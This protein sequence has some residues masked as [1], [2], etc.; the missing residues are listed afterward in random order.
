MRNVIAF[1]VALGLVAAIFWLTRSE[2]DVRRP[3]VATASGSA[4]RAEPTVAPTKIDAPSV[5]RLDKPAREALRAQIAAARA[6]SSGSSSAADPAR[7]P[8]D[9]MTLELSSP[10]QETL[11]PTIPIVAECYA[12]Q[13]G[14]REA[15]AQVMLTTDPVL[16]TVI[17]TTEITDANGEP[18]PPTVDACMRDTIDSLAL[19]PLSERPG[20]LLVKYTFELD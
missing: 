11:K 12:D 15:V 2:E 9:T 17:D 18:L 4:P 19:P 1:V 3:V 5:R 6:A 14:L 16:G 10:L 7:A 20:R 8:D 13:P